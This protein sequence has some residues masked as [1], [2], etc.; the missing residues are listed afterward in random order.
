MCVC[1]ARGSRYSATMEIGPPKPC[2]MWFFSP[3]SIVALHL[4]ALCVCVHVYTPVSPVHL[5]LASIGGS[6]ILTCAHGRTKH[7]ELD[8]QNSQKNGAYTQNEGYA[9]QGMVLGVA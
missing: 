5:G 8:P 1:I 6:M 4:D 2:H 9:G 7:I 3:N